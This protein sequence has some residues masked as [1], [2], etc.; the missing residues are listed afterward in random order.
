VELGAQVVQQRQGGRSLQD[1]DQ[2]GHVG[3]RVL[4]CPCQCAND[5]PAYVRA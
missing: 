2:E 1:Q 4:L 3:V 5:P